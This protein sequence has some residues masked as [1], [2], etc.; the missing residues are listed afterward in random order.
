MCTGEGNG[1]PLQCS[2]LEIPGTGEPGGLPSVGSHSRTRLK[3]LSS[4][5][6][7]VCRVFFF[8][9]YFIL[10][11]HSNVIDLQSVFCFMFTDRQFTG[12]SIHAQFLEL[13]F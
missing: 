4:S 9:F 13:L 8:F 10:N 11:F 12:I 6:S 5:S 1:N 7:R 2:R 3:Q